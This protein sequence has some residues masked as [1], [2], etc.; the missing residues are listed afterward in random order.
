MNIKPA[1]GQH[2]ALYTELNALN[3][4]RQTAKDDQPMALRQA[5]QQFEQVF[6]SMLMKSMREANKSF[7]EDNFLNSSQVQFYEEMLDS[8][9]T[10]E[11]AQ[12][13][14]MGLADV[15]VKQLSRQDNSV[16][17]Q[18]SQEEMEARFKLSTAERLLNRA[19]DT[20][21]DA[22]AN[23]VPGEPESAI[24]TEQ[25]P[26]A[27]AAFSQVRI[28]PS[29]IAEDIQPD[30]NLP[31][32][33]ETPEEFVQSLMSVAQ[34][35]AGEIGVDPK[36]LLAQA[37]L[38]TGWGKYLVQRGA[39]QSS[40]NLF[41]IKADGRWQGERAS[42]STLE[43]RDGI[44]RRETASF[45][46]YESYEDSFRDYVDFLKSSPRYQQALE[47]V[48]DPYDYLHQLQQAGYATD[49]QY[50]EKISTILDGDLLAS[51]KPESPEG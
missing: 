4:I 20:A 24:L 1:S 40:H 49:P 33:F 47:A 46:A 19:L 43:Y 30:A 10:L 35:V 3:K 13:G 7:G 16:Q 31:A 18:P 45:R 26:M 21:S 14:G 38:E 34:S 8:Q 17:S 5:A 44:A 39:D 6:M 32:R 50:A 22:A 12:S 9:M 28:N 51:V 11:L 2:S 27:P 42:A 15:L 23:A 41:N 48:A 29:R 36:V 25:P 37:A